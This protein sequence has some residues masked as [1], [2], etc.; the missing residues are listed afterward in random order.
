MKNLPEE[1]EFLHSW[2]LLLIVVLVIFFLFFNN[3]LI[4]NLPMIGITLFLFA[5]NNLRLNL[6]FKIF[7]HALFFSMT[8]FIFSTMNPSADLQKGKVFYFLGKKYYEMSLNQ[9]MSTSLKIFCLS[10]ISMCSASVIDYTKVILY[11]IVNQGLKLIWGYPILLAI[12]SV[13]LFKNEL[14]RIKINARFRELPF[15]DRVAVFFPLLVFAIRHSERGAMSLASRGLSDSKTFF[16]AYET[17]LRDRLIFTSFLLIYF[18]LTISL[19][20]SSQ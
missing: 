15:N 8:I 17:N 11:L 7:S 4:F 10:L 3:S 12:N 1:Q 14:E 9:G 5:K 18:V 19:F 6:F 2:Y 20:F 13:L 16:S